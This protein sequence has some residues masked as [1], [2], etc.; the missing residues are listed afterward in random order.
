MTM[1]R[2]NNTNSSEGELRIRLDVG[3]SM[4][5]YYLGSDTFEHNG[6]ELTK[7]LFKNDDGET[8]SIVGSYVLNTEL[9]QVEKGTRTRVTYNGKG[10]NKR[11]KPYHKWTVEFDDEDKVAV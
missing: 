3:Q 1:K 6:D 9:K 4:E 8:N 11:G 2:L 7:H 5:G 10:T